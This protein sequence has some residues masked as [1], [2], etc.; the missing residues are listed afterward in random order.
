MLLNGVRLYTVYTNS[1]N[2]LLFGFNSANLY[3]FNT[4]CESN[5]YRLILSLINDTPTMR[6]EY[7]FYICFLC[8]LGFRIT[9]YF[10]QM[11]FVLLRLNRSYNR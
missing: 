1:L 9:G 7:R 3:E 2:G 6:S 11:N 5:F 4:M 10:M 8:G